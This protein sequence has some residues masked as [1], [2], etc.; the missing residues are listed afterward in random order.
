MALFLG[1][2]EMR[3]PIQVL[4]YPVRLMRN[5]QRYLLLRRLP[6]RGGFWQGVTGGLEESED[7][8]TAAKR[9]L[10]EET[11]FAMFSL[12]QTGYS[13][14]FPVDEPYR[15][16]YE[17]GVREITEYVFVAR[18]DD[19]REPVLDP[20]EHVEYRWLSVSQALE[21]LAYPENKQALRECDGLVKAWECERDR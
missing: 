20:G 6:G 2:S 18:I 4:V 8:T 9:E 19:Q 5:E 12:E 21:L 16:L 15:H 11:G 10:V 13:Y 1:C 7:V 3:R 17:A 14:S